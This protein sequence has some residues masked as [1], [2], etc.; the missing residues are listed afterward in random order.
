MFD[1]SLP[2]QDDSGSGKN[3]VT[4]LTKRD[5]ASIDAPSPAVRVRPK[6]E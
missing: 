2:K 3:G 1:S 5:H 4:R 6:D